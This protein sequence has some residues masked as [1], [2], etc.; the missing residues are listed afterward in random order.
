MNETV[1]MF[2]QATDKFMPDSQDLHMVLV[3]HSLKT[4]IEKFKET[5]DLQYIYQNRLDIA[6]F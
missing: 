3:D 4:R 5:G 2:L 6:S 1:N